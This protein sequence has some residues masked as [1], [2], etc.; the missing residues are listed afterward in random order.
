MCILTAR[1]K[2]DQSLYNTRHSLRHKNGALKT[3]GQ[4]AADQ[5]PHGCGRLYATITY[6]SYALPTDGFIFD[7]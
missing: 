4:K 7:I 5:L 2:F 1:S 3:R 6:I